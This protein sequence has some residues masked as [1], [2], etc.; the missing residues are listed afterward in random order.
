[1]RNKDQI[2]KTVAFAKE[3][4]MISAIDMDGFTRINMET[5]ISNKIKKD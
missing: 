5:E 3:Q 4:P 1:M 2:A